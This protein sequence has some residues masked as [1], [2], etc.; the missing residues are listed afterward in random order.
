MVAQHVA[1]LDARRDGLEHAALPFRALFGALPVGDVADDDREM[2]TGRRSACARRS[3]S[4][5]KVD[6][7][8]PAAGRV[9]LGGEEAR[10]LAGAQRLLE[11]AAQLVAST[12]R[13]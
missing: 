1:Q 10:L 11:R 3:K 13:A 7:V 6:A 2:R 12:R 5:G 4:I 8:A 9:T